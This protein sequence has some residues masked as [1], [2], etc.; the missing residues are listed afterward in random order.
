MTDQHDIDT[1]NCNTADPV[2]TDEATVVADVSPVEESAA[3]TPTNR[4]ASFAAEQR[5]PANLRAVPG[6][7]AVR[8]VSIAW[9]EDICLERCPGTFGY[10]QLTCIMFC[11]ICYTIHDFSPTRPK[12][13][14]SP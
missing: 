7:L 5:T 3:A 14:P 6:V 10:S 13:A 4:R 8:A 12:V 9:A 1:Q 11:Y 2:S